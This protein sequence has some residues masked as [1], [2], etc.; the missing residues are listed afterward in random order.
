MYSNGNWILKLMFA[1]C[2]TLALEPGLWAQARVWVRP[3]P[4][5]P[6]D[7][8]REVFNAGQ[9]FFD[10]YRFTEAEN[11]FR[12]IIRR[13]PKN[14]I[15]DR[16]DYYLIRTLMQLGRKNDALSLI[17]EFSKQY[18]KSNWFDDVE[19]LRI[20]LTN[21]IPP[22]AESIL[23]PNF[24]PAPPAPSAPFGAIVPINAGSGIP[25]AP[26]APPSPFGVHGFQSPDPEIS[27]QQEILGVFF[28]NNFDRALEI[29]SERL[30]ANPAD[31]VV[32]S[33]LYLVAGSRSAQ[34][35]PMLTGLIKNSP[36]PKARRDAIFWLGQW[37]GD[38]DTV[39]DTLVSLLP[40]LADADSAVVAQSLSQIPTERAFNALATIARD[41]TKTEK[42][43]T[44]AVFWIGQA[45][46]AS[47]IGLLSD[48]YKNSMDN[49]RIRQQVMFALSQTRQPQAVA[50]IGN[51]AST[52]PDV[53]VRKQAVHWL[54]QIRSPEASQALEKLLQ[55]K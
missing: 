10:E 35:L 43:R 19:E 24:P 1:V 53:E 26:V 46:S 6:A 11:R 9:R 55:R 16:A 50:L 41:K 8:A 39:V 7:E 47:R 44:N 49:S 34:A 17:N 40:S 13:F 54:G 15:A 4:L 18:P 33:N 28:R 52:D 20:Q 38:K 36:N 3:H 29:A 48:I 30:K 22:K 45:R 42:V 21:Q 5:M 51:A 37:Q 12:D 27:F 31:P 14:P 23:L 25:P 32:L 2:V